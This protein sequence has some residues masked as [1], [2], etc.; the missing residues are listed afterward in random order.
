MGKDKSDSR[1][2]AGLCY[3]PFMLVNIVAILYILIKK[4]DDKFA[5]FHALQA[6]ALFILLFIAM[7]AVMITVYLPL[8]T[9]QMK[10]MAG[11]LKS[12]GSAN[13]MAVFSSMF[14]VYAQMIPFMLAGLLVIVA[15]IAIGVLVALGR[16]IRVPILAGFVSRFA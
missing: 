14:A 1:I 10:A 12:G 15:F 6:L 7:Q 4:G 8:M 9:Q 16:D 13:G 3:V 5:K 11:T 2:L